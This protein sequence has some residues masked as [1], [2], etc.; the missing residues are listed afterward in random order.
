[1]TEKLRVF[2]THF[3]IALLFFIFYRAFFLTLLFVFDVVLYFILFFTFYFPLT[4]TVPVVH[5]QETR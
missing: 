4:L 1:M 2:F 3:P 5:D